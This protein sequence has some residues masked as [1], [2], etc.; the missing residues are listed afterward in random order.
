LDSSNAASNSL[1]LVLT[2]TPATQVPIS[3]PG[4][5]V[6]VANA[7]GADQ[8]VI[9]PDGNWIAIIAGSTS[10]NSLYLLNVANPGTVTL[11]SPPIPGG[12]A[13]FASQPTFTSDSK[14]VY[15]LASVA[16]GLHKSIYLVP[17]GS[18]PSTPILVSKQ[19]DPAT[20]D[21]IS[22]Y[23]VAPDQSSIV[24]EANRN[25]R[26]GVFYID[27]T[28]LAVEN[29]IDQPV[30]GNAVTSSTVGLAPG[31]GGSNTGKA[32]AYDV[33]VPVTLPTAIGIYVAN[34]SATPNPQFVIQLETVLGFSPDDKKLL[35]TD[36]ARVTEI[37]AG[38]G[39]SGTQIGVGN[40]AWYDS[41][42]NVVLVQNPASSGV[43]LSYNTRPFASP[44][45]VTPS[46]TVAYGVDVSGFAQGV[47]LLAEGQA[48][49]SAPATANLQLVNVLALNGNSSQPQPFYLSSLGS[50]PS[51]QSPTH[52]TSY[53]SKIVTQ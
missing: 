13:A 40:Q 43:T 33:G 31:L 29:E 50:T 34:I 52:L 12:A 17:L 20:S 6:P 15:F 48:G 27:P 7:G 37:G 22:F 35:Y 4:G 14:S 9:S 16:G 24:E 3:L 8:F 10:N 41:S 46:G 1:S 49:A 45:A 32:V 19:S 2:A 5:A 25:G 42:G 30:A 36:S 18:P 11:V 23:S 38:A 26:E 39:N 53:V 47:V 28:K 51:L 21:D 44:Q